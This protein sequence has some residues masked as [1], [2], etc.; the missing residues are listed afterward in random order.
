MTV[1]AAVKVAVTDVSPVG[2]GG[3]IITSGLA[4]VTHYLKVR[5][6]RYVVLPGGVGQ[7]CRPSDGAVL[8]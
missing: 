7:G 4:I 1:V 3:I 5:M 8:D 2:G 6:V